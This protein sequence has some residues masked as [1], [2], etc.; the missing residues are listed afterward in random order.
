MNRYVVAGARLS[1]LVGTLLVGR[2]SRPA[3][4]ELS[5]MTMKPFAHDAA[6]KVWSPDGKTVAF[7]SNASGKMQISLKRLGSASDTVLLSRAKGL[8][9]MGWAN[10]GSQVLFTE[11]GDHF[12]DAAHLELISSAGGEPEPVMDLGGWGTLSADGTKLGAFLQGDDKNA[13]VWISDPLGSELKQ[14][15][16]APFKTKEVV[17]WGWVA[18]A[19]DGK[20]LALMQ[21]VGKNAEMWILPY[22]AGSRAPFRVFDKVRFGTDAQFLSWMP[23]SRH[24]VMSFRSE[25]TAPHHLWY[26]DTVSGTMSQL[27]FGTTGETWPVVSRS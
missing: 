12:R 17:G 15:L 6:F 19:P 7:S 9:V 10:K 16:P 13:G 3:G 5:R 27:T 24:G 4:V 1:L 23:D 20:K 8:A 18:F 25:P 2:F 26:A 21:N 11:N 14:Y 22:P